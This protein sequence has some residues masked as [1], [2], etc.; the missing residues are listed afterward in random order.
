MKP[1][2]LHFGDEL[3][4]AGLA[5]LP[6]AWMADGTIVYGEAITADQRS[7][8][9]AVLAAHDAAAT[10]VPASITPWQARQALNEMGMRDAVET[11][12]AAA[13]RG[14]KDAWEY[15][16]TVDR[17]SP[18]IEAMAPALGLTEAQ[19]DALFRLAASKV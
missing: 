1:I 11:A 6:V 7:A 10:P 9:E 16:L 8:F 15:G 13:P 19:I 17:H 3:A 18:F 5:G 2:G 14:I 4:A 12:L